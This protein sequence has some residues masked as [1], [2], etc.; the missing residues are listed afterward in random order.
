M[1][2][3]KFILVGYLHKELDRALL[4]MDWFSTWLVS[5]MGLTVANRILKVPMG[6][7]FAPHYKIS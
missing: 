2:E 3:S 4:S 7:M 5:K 1:N 6:N